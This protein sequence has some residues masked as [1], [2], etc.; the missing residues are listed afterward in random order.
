MDTAMAKLVGEFKLIEQIKRRNYSNYPLTNAELKGQT[1]Y[2]KNNYFKHL[3][4][5]LTQRGET[6]ENQRYLFCRMLKGV[7]AEQEIEEHLRQAMEIEIEEYEEFMEQL[8]GM[9]LRYR[10]VLDALLIAC[11]DVYSDEQKE[12]LALFMESLKVGLDEAA[13]ICGIARSILEQDEKSYCQTMKENLAF[14]FW[15]F[16]HEYAAAFAGKDLC[17]ITEQSLFLYFSEKTELS[18]KRLADMGVANGAIEGYEE[19]VIGNA[20][21]SLRQEDLEIKGIG[22]AVFIGCKFDGTV[23]NSIND[24]GKFAVNL[25]EDKKVEFQNCEFMN[26]SNRAMYVECGVDAA[27]LFHACRFHKCYLEESRE[28]FFG[29]DKVGCVIWAG[30]AC[31]L[32]IQESEFVMC[33]IIA[34]YV[35]IGYYNQI[36]L[37][38]SATVRKCRFQH[39]SVYENRL[40]LE[41]IRLDLYSRLF[42]ID[43]VNEECVL[44]DSAPFSD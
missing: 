17:E 18:K 28:S 29:R 14:P 32:M 23:Q 20:V 35:S 41:K 42:T 30:Q 10:F 33:G 15:D 39:C 44:T 11:S 16:A 13:F 9:T 27:I 7:E 38:Q 3:A 37:N 31:N 22:K 26:F 1:D 34:S 25:K 4:L 6:S 36:I 24:C 43:S 40:E 21:F 5:V 8:R 19:V 2:I 12:L